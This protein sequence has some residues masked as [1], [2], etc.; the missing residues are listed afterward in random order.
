MIFCWYWED[1]FTY[2]RREDLR[3]NGHLVRKFL[4]LMHNVLFR[5]QRSLFTFYCNFDISGEFVNR[6]EMMSHFFKRNAHTHIPYLCTT[7]LLV[8]QSLHLV[9]GMWNRGLKQL[10]CYRFSKGLQIHKPHESTF[11]LLYW[12]CLYSLHLERSLHYCMLQDHYS[13]YDD[14]GNGTKAKVSG[15]G[16][17]S[18]N[19]I[20]AE[21]GSRGR[22]RGKVWRTLTVSEASRLGLADI[23]VLTIIRTCNKP[24][25]KL[26]GRRAAATCRH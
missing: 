19:E 15:V 24:E 6:L 22:W 8:M 12:S 4:Y 13:R 11:S 2:K 1:L 18:R 21:C 25:R 14:L 5:L 20:R 17:W 9:F 10:T 16:V 7:V 26:K 3:I 23:F